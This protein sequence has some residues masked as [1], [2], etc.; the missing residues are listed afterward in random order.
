VK[1]E[2]DYRDFLQ[3]ILAACQSIIRFTDGMTL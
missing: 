1:A 3:D 2:R